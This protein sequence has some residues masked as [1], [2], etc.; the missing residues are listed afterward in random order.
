MHEPLATL[1]RPVDLEGLAALGA[2]HDAL[3]IG[4]GMATG[5]AGSAALAGALGLG[6]PIVLDAGA[7]SQIAADSGPNWRAPADVAAVLTPHAGEFDRLWPDIARAGWSKLDQARAAAERCRAVVVLKGA[8]TVIANPDGR[9]VIN[10]HASPWLATAGAGDVLAGMIGG[11][12]AQGMGPFEA[13]CAS[14]WLHG[15]AGLRLG[16]GLIADDLIPAVP[17]VLRALLG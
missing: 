13:A 11:L 16:P 2:Q 17:Q 9:A 15:D 6:R 12:M 14:V 8:D 1:I 5:A 7:L 10:V 4:P 3:V